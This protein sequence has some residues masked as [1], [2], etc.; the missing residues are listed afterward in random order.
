MHSREP[1]P[2]ANPSAVPAGGPGVGPGAPQE[3][4]GK[5]RLTY[6]SYLRVPELLDLQH[7]MS[8]PVHHDELL[9]IVSHQVYELWFKQMLHELRAVCGWMDA[10][11]PDRAHQL[12]ERVHRIQTLLIEQ[13]PVLETMFSVEF[14]KFREHLRPASGF[15]SVQFRLLEFLAGWKNEKMIAMVGDDDAARAQMEKVLGE[16]TVFDHLLR[17]IARRGFKVPADVLSRD[18]RVLYVGDDRVVE[19]LLPIYKDSEAHYGLFRLCEHL[20]EFDERLSLWRFHHVKMVERMIG[21][22]VGTGGSSGARYLASTVSN[23]LYPDLWSVRDKLGAL[24]P[25]EYGR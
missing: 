4:I 6:G 11:K 19:A 24:A 10:D 16:P 21:G 20:L 1:D 15:Q 8:S 9:F 3:P 14:R 7:A 25:G 18:V 17:L 2:A 13:I 12:L 5:G 22:L 23:R